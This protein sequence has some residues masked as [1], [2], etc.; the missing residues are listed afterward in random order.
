MFEVGSVCIKIAG[1][2]S[3]NFCAVVKKIDDNLV[4]IEGNVRRRKCS[5]KHLQPQNIKLELKDDASYEDVMKAFKKQG[6]VTKEKEGFKGKVQ[7]KK[8]GKAK[9]TEKQ[10]EKPAKE[11][12]AEPTE[13]KSAEE[14]KVEEKPK[15]AP[16]KKAP[17]PKKEE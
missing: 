5:L 6:I 17:K 3:N 2:D 7:E 9:P 15:K 16:V 11:K 14:A 4:L 1:R 8:P 13:V 10:V 12:P